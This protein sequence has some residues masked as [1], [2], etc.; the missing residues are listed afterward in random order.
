[1]EKKIDSFFSEKISIIILLLVAT[2][3]IVLTTQIY[4]FE[5]MLLSD[6]ISYISTAENLKNYFTKLVRSCQEALTVQCVLFSL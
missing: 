5:N 2:L 1:M 4:T 6:A 3:T